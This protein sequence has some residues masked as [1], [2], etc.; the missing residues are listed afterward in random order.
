MEKKSGG[1]KNK[2]AT[3]NDR[4]NKPTSGDYASN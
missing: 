4:N 3:V 1:G 2:S